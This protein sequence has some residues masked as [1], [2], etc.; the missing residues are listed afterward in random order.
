MANPV[1]WNLKAKSS[2]Y[3]FLKIKE[4]LKMAGASGDLIWPP[5]SKKSQLKQVDL[6]H[7]S[8]GFE[9]LQG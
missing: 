8:S 7:I 4:Q 5:G 6:H 9:Y 3:S 1:S 2:F